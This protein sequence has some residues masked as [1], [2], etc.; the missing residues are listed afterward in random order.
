MIDRSRT[1]LAEPRREHGVPLLCE[2]WGVRQDRLVALT[3]LVICVLPLSGCQHAS[4]RTNK[5][6]A[7]DRW[8]EVKGRFKSQ[9]A[10]QQYDER[11]YEKAL[12][13]AT[14]AIT[15]DPKKVEAYVVLARAQVELGRLASAQATIDAAH[16]VPLHAA[17]LSYLAGVIHEQRGDF[18]EAM[19]QYRDARSTDPRQ[20]DFLIA[21]VECLVSLGRDDDA[22]A[23]LGENTSRYNE[24]GE[25][26]ALGGRLLAKRGDARAAIDRYRRAL[27]GLGGNKWVARELGL[28]LVRE[29]RYAE[30]VELLRPLI[31]ERTEGTMEE[32]SVRRALAEAYVFLGL[33]QDAK[34]LLVEY[35][36]V[37]PEDVAAEVLLAKVAL[38]TNDLSTAIDAVSAAHRLAPADAE[39]GLVRATVQ[40]RRGEYAAAEA[41]LLEV[42]AHTP[43]DADA[44]C[45]MA[46]VLR[47]R[48]KIERAKTYFLQALEIEPD[49]AWAKSGLTALRR[50]TLPASE[51]EESSPGSKLTAVETHRVR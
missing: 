4:K 15:L 9:L 48:Q 45:L 39:V 43:E 38:A 18:D 16:Q 31:Q 25:L 35:V 22:L 40:W 32:T 23:L 11:Q 3:L 17:E 2:Q 49:S 12:Q 51:D 24:D 29:R 44:H 13:T 21:E 41:S 8:N 36:R 10:Q 7:A 28:L 47:A 30:S 33:P 19:K 46:E 42:L 6:Q 14:E 20:V 26:A 50:E 5:E 34:P 27:A 1:N 37:R